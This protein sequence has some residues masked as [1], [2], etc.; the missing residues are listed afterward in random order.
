MERLIKVSTESDILTEYVGTP[1]GNL[2]QYHNLNT[3]FQ[4]YEKAPLL[5]GMCMDHRKRLNIPK[6]FA[7]IIRTGG[8]NLNYSE[9]HISYALGVGGINHIALIGHNNCGMVNINERKLAFIEGLEKSAGWSRE[10]AT[11][12]FEA[13]VDKY[14]IG[15]EIDFILS[16]TLQLRKNFPKIV[17]APL[18][19]SV[20]DN[21]LYL[22]S[23]QN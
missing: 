18:M 5:I 23:E 10:K 1:I 2:L 14:D 16:Q 21:K 8:A 22:I 12:Y 11:E 3:E 17:I 9:F 4:N 15:N 7:Y 6:K 20:N 13:N 19:Y